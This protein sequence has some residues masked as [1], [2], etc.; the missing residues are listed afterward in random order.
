[1]KAK[2]RKYQVVIEET[3]NECGRRIEPPVRKC[4]VMAVIENPLAGRYQE[5]LEEL[6]VNLNE[7]EVE[8]E[9]DEII[10]VYCE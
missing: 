8:V 3:H 5:D 7:L 9:G 2:V 4:T 10:K 6:I 1:M